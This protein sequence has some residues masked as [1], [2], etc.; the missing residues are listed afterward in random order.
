VG[1]YHGEALGT[2]TTVHGMRVHVVVTTYRLQR[3]QG[4]LDVRQN[5]SMQVLQRVMRAATV[6]FRIVLRAAAC[7]TSNVMRFRA[8]ESCFKSDVSMVLTAQLLP[9]E[10]PAIHA[11]RDGPGRV[12]M[13]VS[14]RSAFPH[15]IAALQTDLHAFFQE[16]F[17][18][19]PVHKLS[20]EEPDGLGH[21]AVQASNS[22]CTVW[23]CHISKYALL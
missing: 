21:K 14:I 9:C 13:R 22:D 2:C 18:G 20:G 4:A 3:C 17:E 7:T 12:V 11:D 1:L 19:E 5:S 15:V 10:R 23:G 16:L 8:G 6:L